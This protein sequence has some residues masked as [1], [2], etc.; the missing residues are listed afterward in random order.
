[1]NNKYSIKHLSIAERLNILMFYKVP[2][3]DKMSD[4]DLYQ[5]KL[6]LLLYSRN[7]DMLKKAAKWLLSLW[8]S[9]IITLLITAT[10][11]FFNN[12]KVFGQSDAIGLYWQII[13]LVIVMA[14]L[15]S[16]IFIVFTLSIYSMNNIIWWRLKCLNDY[17]GIESFMDIK[18]N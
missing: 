3:F 11:I 4:N 10:T 1:M 18:S 15:I 8:I 16:V 6:K 14:L 9:T 7:F 13:G 17:M 12:I 5:Y 2:N